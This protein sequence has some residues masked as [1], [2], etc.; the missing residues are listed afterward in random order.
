MWYY[1]VKT[2]QP[3]RPSADEQIDKMWSS[4]VVEYYSATKREEALTG[5]TV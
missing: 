5:A 4:G 3:K 1:M 2:E